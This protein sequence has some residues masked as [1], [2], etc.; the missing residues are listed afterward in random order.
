MANVDIMVSRSQTYTLL[1]PTANP[2]N[3]ANSFAPM[4]ST[5]PTNPR[6]SSGLNIT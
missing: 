6:S 5:N 1:N 4:N 2:T 3:P